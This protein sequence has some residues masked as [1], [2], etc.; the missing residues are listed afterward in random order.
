MPERQK[1]GAPCASILEDLG[2]WLQQQIS[3]D[4]SRRRSVMESLD[5]E[6]LSSRLPKLVKYPHFWQNPVAV[7]CLVYEFALPVE[8]RSYAAAV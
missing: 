6:R 5:D 7:Q 2:E 4:Q 1:E 8:S 3:K